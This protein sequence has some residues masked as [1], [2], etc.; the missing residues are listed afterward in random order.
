M[1]TETVVASS[2]LFALAENQSMCGGG[3]GWGRVGGQRR[4]PAGETFPTTILYWIHSGT[5]MKEE[6]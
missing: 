4:Q 3:D 6:Q 1:G 5:Y 2:L